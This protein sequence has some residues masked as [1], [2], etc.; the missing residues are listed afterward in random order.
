M[1]PD[2]LISALSQ[3]DLC[4]SLLYGTWDYEEFRE[5]H[6]KD[7]LQMMDDWEHSGAF[8]EDAPEEIG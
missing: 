6:L 7:F 8:P 3:P 4:R 5:K 2:C 1:L